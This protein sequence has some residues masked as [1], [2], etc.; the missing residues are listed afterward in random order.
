MG[1]ISEQI[2]LQGRDIHMK[3]LVTEAIKICITMSY[4]FTITRMAIIQKTGIGEEEG[5]LE[6]WYSTIRVVIQHSQVRESVSVSP[7]VKQ[8]LPIGPSNSTSVYLTPKIKTYV[9]KKYTWIFRA[10]LFIVAK[11][12]K[13]PKYPPKGE[14]INKM[15]CF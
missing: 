2:V 6:L 3:S 15:G 14:C 7:N 5:R 8:R 4:H 11:N 10:P 13:Q 9:P 12:Y 1:K